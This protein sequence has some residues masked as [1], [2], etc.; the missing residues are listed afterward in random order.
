MCGSSSSVMPPP[1]SQTSMRTLSPARR[2]PNRILPLLVYRIAFDSRLRIIL[3]EH[4]PVTGDDE[5][6]N[7]DTPLE[8]SLPYRHGEVSRERLEDF[9]HRKLAHGRMQVSGF[10]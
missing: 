10:Q 9:A 4:T 7:N 8:P 1:L 3:R 2:H 5:F 6:G